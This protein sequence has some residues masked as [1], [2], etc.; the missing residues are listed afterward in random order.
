MN[1]LFQIHGEKDVYLFDQQDRFVLTEREIEEFYRGRAFAGLLREE[2]R[3]LGKKFRLVPGIAVHQPPLAPHL[4]C[5]ANNVSVSVSIWFA[6]RSLDR[7]AKVYQANSC[8]RQLGL[9]PTPPGVSG[10]SDRLKV[11]AL[12]AVSK[13]NPVTQRELLYSGI[14]RI[15]APVKLAKR[16]FG[17]ARA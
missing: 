4:I 12:S 15:S 9:R 13:S 10:L 6:L 11:A 1:F 3:H 17:Q 8:L 14:E 7:R 5:N 2:T 16:V